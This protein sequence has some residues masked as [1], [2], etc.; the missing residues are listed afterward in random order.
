M[1]ITGGEEKGWTNIL[2]GLPRPP[3]GEPKST[4]WTLAP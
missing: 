3:E 4:D 1:P 2:T